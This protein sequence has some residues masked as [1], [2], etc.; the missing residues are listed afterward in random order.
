[1]LFAV[2]VP[3]RPGLTYFFVTF[4][5]TEQYGESEYPIGVSTAFMAQ[6]N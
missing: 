5:S 2:F 1:M 6:L 4:E 3:Q